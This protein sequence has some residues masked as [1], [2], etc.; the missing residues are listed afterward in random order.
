MSASSILKRK[1]NHWSG[2][3]VGDVTLTPNTEKGWAFLA[4]RHNCKPVERKELGT[5]LSS[6]KRAANTYM[7]TEGYVPDGEWEEQ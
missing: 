7:R 6:A 2:K 3:A 1:Y 5:F 4:N